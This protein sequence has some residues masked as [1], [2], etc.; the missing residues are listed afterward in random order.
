VYILH[1]FVGYYL[2]P[3]LARGFFGFREFPR[4]W[5]SV[6]WQ[7]VCSIAVAALSFHFYESRWL[8][9]KRRWSPAPGEKLA[10]MA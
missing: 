6:I 8:A 10:A 9:L 4:E 7:S 3:I 2:A 1:I 5:E